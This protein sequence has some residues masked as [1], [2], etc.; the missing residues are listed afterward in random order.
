M[1]AATQQGDGSGMTPPEGWYRS[2]SEAATAWHW[3]GQW[4]SGVA[5]PTGSFVGYAR[6]DEI[7]VFPRSHNSSAHSQSCGSPAHPCRVSSLRRPRYR[8]PLW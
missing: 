4:F 6:A 3:A 8:T 2:I 7:A 1:E 5:T